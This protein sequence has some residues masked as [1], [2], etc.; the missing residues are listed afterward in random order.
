LRANEIELEVFCERRIAFRTETD[1]VNGIVD[2]LILYRQNGTVIAA[3]VIDYKTDTANSAGD[4]ET[5]CE[6]YHNQLRQ[7]ERS[8]Q[9]IYGLD[10]SRIVSRLGLLSVGQFV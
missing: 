6:F 4:I 2:R 3:D 5:L 8:M 1:L 10:S 7:Y 9:T